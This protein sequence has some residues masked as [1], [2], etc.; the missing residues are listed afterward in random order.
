M[1]KLKKSLNIA[2]ILG[3]FLAF[4]MLASPFYVGV[5]AAQSFNSAP[6]VSQ[7][8]LSSTVMQQINMIKKTAIENKQHFDIN[9]TNAVNSISEINGELQSQSNFRSL[10]SSLP[11]VSFAINLG[12][13]STTS[14]LDAYFQLFSYS[15]GFSSQ[16]TWTYNYSSGQL[17]GPT[18]S[19]S[20]EMYNALSDTNSVGTSSTNDNN[21]GIVA[22][23]SNPYWDGYEYYDS[24][25]GAYDINP[26]TAASVNVNVVSFSEPPSGQKV[27][28]VLWD[29][30]YYPIYRVASV[31]LGLSNGN[32]GSGGLIQT[33][34]GYTDQSGSYYVWY[35]IYPTI[36]STNYP[37]LSSYPIHVGDILNL[38]VYQSG[39]YWYFEAYDYSTGHT[40][41]ASMASNENAYFA[42]DIVEATTYDYSGTDITQQIPQ[43]DTAINFEGSD[44]WGA[45]PGGSYESI[46]MTSLYDNG[47]YNQ[48]YLQQDSNQANNVNHYYIMATGT[49]DTSIYGYSQENWVN[50]YYNLYG[51]Q[52][53][54]PSSGG[55]GGGC[56]QNGTMVSISRTQSVPVQDLRVGEHILSY[57][58]VD[59]KLVQEKVSSINITNVTSII[60]INNGLL[61]VSGAHDQPIFVKLSNGSE[62]WIMVGYLNTTDHIFDPLDN[63]WVQVTSIHVLHGNYTVYDLY[64]TKIFY[65]DGY[66]RSNYIANG[67][68]LDQKLR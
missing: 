7:N 5:S 67:I 60:N 27:T 29:G 14:V 49:Q 42:Q 23:N 66:L 65:E 10:E 38:N 35:E 47:W 62:Q 13:Q 43:F 26:I 57:N 4:L 30:T 61:Y 8:A 51:G 16:Y 12:F 25:V 3:I 44:I 34:Y 54:P 64:G 31:W 20:Q 50:S 40:Y 45:G 6:T 33:G 32:G 21:T 56:V 17:T 36:A 63:T 52:N 41:T 18:V 28:S 59:N 9:G 46:T 39:G 48:Y 2:I 55:S 22:Y 1:I 68:L 11:N 24:Y 53:S 19:I 15:N 37:G 58:T